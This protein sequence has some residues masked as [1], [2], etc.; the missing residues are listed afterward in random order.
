[1][2]NLRLKFSI[3]HRIYL[4]VFVML[5]G[6]FGVL[7]ASIHSFES[8]YYKNSYERGQRAVTRMAGIISFEAENGKLREESESVT[9]QNIFNLV[10]KVF[11]TPTD[12]YWIFSSSSKMV[13]HPIYP[14]LNGR[15]LHTILD[16]QNRVIFKDLDKIIK[17]K[18]DGFYR[19]YWPSK[20]EVG[21][22]EE[23]NERVS[24]IRMIP[25][26]SWGIGRGVYTEDIKNEMVLV[27]R[28]LGFFVF[29]ITIISVSGVYWV[30]R[31]FAN[32]VVEL[33]H[34]LKQIAKGNLDLQITQKD[35]TD[36]I[37]DMARTIQSFL[38][39]LKQVAALEAQKAR[40]EEM[41]SEFISVVSHELR[42]PLTSIRGSL[43]LMVGA[44]SQQL[45]DQVNQL[46]SIAY[47]NCERLILL[48]NDVLDI[49]KIESGQMRL[50]MKVESLSDIMR[51]AV[52]STKAYADKYFVRFECKF[53][54][55][56]VFINVDAARLV[57]I[58]VN[59][60]SNAAKFSPGGAKVD[61]YTTTKDNV[62]RISIKDYGMGVPEEFRSRIFQKFS[63]A[64]ASQT[65]NKGGSGL[66]LYI[67]KRLAE[68]MGGNIGYKTE[69]S[70]GSVFWVEFPILEAVSGVT[71]SC[72]MDPYL[73][74]S[75]KGVPLI[76]YIGDDME[77]FIPVVREM[78]GAVQFKQ[79]N[80]PEDVEQ[81]LKSENVVLVL[82]SIPISDYPKMMP[83]EKR[84]FVRDKI[85]PIIILSNE[86]VPKDISEN[87]TEVINKSQMSKDR[88]VETIRQY[89]VLS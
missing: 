31:S 30:A 14:H 56:D 59:F 48:I 65:R 89:V 87:V 44:M 64:D 75:P 26:W 84:P 55:P 45:P 62:V 49:N 2:F 37:G 32:P 12:Y 42:T 16:T 83:V 47:K 61:I 78:G 67:C 27:K 82:I 6:I 76:L 13:Y 58:L 5:I 39:S 11:S 85:I 35:R 77:R 71:S 3:A 63:Q 29:I 36:E 25:E 28:R 8:Y 54:D 10:Q 50:E 66:G 57:Q 20:A 68:H 4:I 22:N 88:L 19:Y 46:V 18:G 60:F 80:T 51:Q 41:K 21:I 34:Q 53:P 9:Q 38:E 73:M 43:G 86:R 24:Y 40:V 1:M 74:I 15:D 17:E 33:D 81:I 79:A 23:P 72:L 7:V 69:T 52:E 70:L